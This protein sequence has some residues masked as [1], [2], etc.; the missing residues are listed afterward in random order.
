MVEIVFSWSQ[1]LIL[2]VPLGLLNYGQ[3]NY[4]AVLEPFPL[5]LE[6]SEDKKSE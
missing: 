1:A 6:L 3:G 4:L 5:L 2:I